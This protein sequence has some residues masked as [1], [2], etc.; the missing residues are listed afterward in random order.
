LFVFYFLYWGKVVKA[1]IRTHTHFYMYGCLCA[2]VSIHVPMFQV[3]TESL[4]KQKIPSNWIIDTWE[5]PF[6]FWKLKEVLREKW[7]ELLTLES[8]LYVQ[9]LVC[10][11][12]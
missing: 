11:I 12:L 8:P 7:P 5:P 2:Y 1:L 3:V 4:R 10:N 6:G 9:T